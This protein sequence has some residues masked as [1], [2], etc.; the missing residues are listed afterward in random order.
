MNRFNNKNFRVSSAEIIGLIAFLCLLLGSAFF[1]KSYSDTKGLYN[2]EKTRVDYIIQAPSAEQVTEISQLDHIDRVTPYYYRAVDVQVG[3]RNI[4]TNLF[5]IESAADRDYTS[6]A[7]VLAKNTKSADGNVIFITD[8][9]AQNAGIAVGDMLDIVLDGNPISFAV[10]GV[11][12]SDYRMVGGSLLTIITDEVQSAMKSTKYSG[13]Y[14][15]SNNLAVSDKYFDN[16]YEPKGNL[17]SR[18][19]FDTDEAYQRYLDTQGQDDTTMATFVTADYVSEVSRRNNTKLIRNMILSI[20][21]LVAAYVVMMIIVSLRASG[22]TNHNVLRDV[23]D[24]FTIDQETGMYSRYFTSITTLMLTA[25]IGIAVIGL[26]TGWIKLVSP[27]NIIGICA[28]ALL[29]TVC[30]SIQKNKLTEKFL[31]EQKKYKEEK[32]KEREAKGRVEAEKQA[33]ENEQ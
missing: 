9:F 28:S 21:C 14:I 5:I 31:V 7:D 25:N 26:V 2:I 18:D 11:Y 33:K 30:G 32:R 19:E 20:V 16:E 1:Y 6:F 3:K 24:N 22:Y 10:S 27:L 13:A 4:S 12:Q 8:D 15:A 29:M 23:R 17:R